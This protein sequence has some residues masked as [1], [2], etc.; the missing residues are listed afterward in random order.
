MIMANVDGR[1][2]LRPLKSLSGGGH[3][4]KLSSY[5]IASAYNT[6]LFKGDP[7]E[8]TGTGKNIQQAA[9]ANAD[10]IGVFMGVDYPAS[11]GTP[12][13]GRYWPADTVTKGSVAARAKVHDDPNTIFTIQCESG[14]DFTQAMVGQGCDWVFTHTGDTATGLSGA[15][16]DISALATTNKSLRIMGLYNDPENV[17]G[18]HAVIEVMFAEHVLG[19]VV[20]GVGGI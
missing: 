14:T 2:G 20:A 7:V 17:V 8:M 9:A 11:D 13:F 15:E 3:P 4:A 16:A 5:T 10:N 12:T 18:E 6:D 19:R 1:F